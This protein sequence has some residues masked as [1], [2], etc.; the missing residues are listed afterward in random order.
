MDQCNWGQLCE[1]SSYG[2]HALVLTMMIAAVV[3]M[4]DVASL[5]KVGFSV[6]AI[7]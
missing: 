1:S 7:L 4:R 5:G 2:N 3:K 6:V